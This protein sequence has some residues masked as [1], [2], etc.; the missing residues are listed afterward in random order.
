MDEPRRPHP[1][2]VIVLAVLAVAGTGSGILQ[3]AVL[4]RSS[5][6]ARSTEISGCRAAY[7]VEFVD[8]PTYRALEAFAE[9]DRPALDAALE[10]G[11]PDEYERLVALSVTDPDA[12]LRECRAD[13]P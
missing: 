10:R 4:G 13:T 6:I 11:D 1:A 7:R 3:L 9:D 8:A 5:A 2:F 12:F